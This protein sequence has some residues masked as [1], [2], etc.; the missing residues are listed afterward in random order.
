MDCAVTTLALGKSA[1]NL[2]ELR[3]RIAEVPQQS[4]SHHFYEALLR[5]VFDD[6]EYR[7]DFAVWARRQLHDNLLAEQLGAIDPMEFESLETLRQEVVDIIED[8]LAEATF[9]PWAA[10]GHEFHFQMVVLDTG[11]RAATPADLAARVPRLSTGSIFYHFVEGRRRPPLKV[12]D[13]SVWLADWGPELE[14]TRD[15]IAAIDYHLWSLTEMRTLIGAALHRLPRDSGGRQRVVRESDDE[16]PEA[17][18][19]PAREARR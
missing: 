11:L 12:D 1:Q 6:P 13:F 3:D 17:A 8:R 16:Q 19:A 7:N 18:D 5:P 4:I 14:P 9:V 15:A 2:R 10:P